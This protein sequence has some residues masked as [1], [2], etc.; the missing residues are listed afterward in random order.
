MSDAVPT[1]L[2]AKLRRHI[3]DAVLGVREVFGERL[4]AVLLVGAAATPARQD[5]GRGALLVVLVDELPTADVGRLAQAARGPMQHGVRIRTLTTDELARS[6]DV[7]AL[8]V[9]DWRDRHLRLAGDDPFEG[10]TIA[11]RDLRHSLEAA[12]RG[13]RRRARNKLLTAL[14]SPGRRGDGSDAVGELLERLLTVAHHG[15]ALA[16]VEPPNEER[17]LLDALAETIDASPNAV[18]TAL[19]ELRARGALTEPLAAL[20]DTGPFVDALCDWIDQLEVE[21]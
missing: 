16:G 10:L 8:E 21:P 13:L 14:A 4:G 18:H 19:H 1:W 7:Y 17:A 15:L 11:P 9:A 2:P 3:A 12:A 20:T 5:R 6:T